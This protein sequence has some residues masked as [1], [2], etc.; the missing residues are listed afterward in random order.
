MKIIG[1]VLLVLVAG[2][3]KTDENELQSKIAA[4]TAA[5]MDYTYLRDF[6]GQPYDVMCV[7]K[8]VR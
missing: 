5:Q 8:R 6:K 2:C 3:S 4:C 1:V 7:A